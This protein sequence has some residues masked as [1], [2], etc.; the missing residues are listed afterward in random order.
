MSKSSHGVA[1]VLLL[2]G[3][4]LSGCLVQIHDYDTSQAVVTWLPLLGTD[5]R[6]FDSACSHF[7]NETPQSQKYYHRC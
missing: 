6:D 7:G 5:E 2:V 4:S 1:L 3:S